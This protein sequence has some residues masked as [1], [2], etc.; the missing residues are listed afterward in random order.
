MAHR[1][2]TDFTAMDLVTPCYP[3]RYVRIAHTDIV[4]PADPED[5]VRSVHTHASTG[6][7][8]EPA[9]LCF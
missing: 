6:L 2:F 5:D 3:H 9:Y 8:L 4:Q 1:F 7:L